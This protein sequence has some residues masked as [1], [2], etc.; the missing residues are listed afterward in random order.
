MLRLIHFVFAPSF[1]C[2]K[3]GEQGQEMMVGVGS[4][5]QVHREMWG[6]GDKEEG[7]A[8]TAQNSPAHPDEAIRQSV[9]QLLPSE[10]D[11]TPPLCRQQ[12]FPGAA[13]TSS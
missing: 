2:L 9:P 5:T 11:T 7:R 8:V 13:D 1:G 4:C 3:W 10:R 6:K 12:I